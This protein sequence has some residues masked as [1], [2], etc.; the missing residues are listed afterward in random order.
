MWI[1]FRVEYDGE[2]KVSILKKKGQT[3]T[4]KPHGFLKHQLY[5]HWTCEHVGHLYDLALGFELSTTRYPRWTKGSRLTPGHATFNSSRIL[6]V[7]TGFVLDFW[8]P[9]FHWEHICYK[10]KLGL[11]PYPKGASSHSTDKICAQLVS[12][13]CNPVEDGQIRCKTQLPPL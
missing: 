4:G 6:M 12:A 7:D 5:F 10:W 13:E 1:I 11:L 8:G 2:Q 3:S 9:S